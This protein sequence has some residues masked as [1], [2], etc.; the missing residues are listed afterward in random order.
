[1]YLLNTFRLPV[2]PLASSVLIFSLPCPP[3]QTCQNAYTRSRNSCITP[4][5]ILS[6]WRLAKEKCDAG[7]IRVL[8]KGT[9]VVDTGKTSVR[10]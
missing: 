7:V 5:A 8:E 6:P 1:M 2:I 9:N 10:R 4:N 3:L